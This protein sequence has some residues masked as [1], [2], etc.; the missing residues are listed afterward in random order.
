VRPLYVLRRGEVVHHIFLCEYVSGRAH[1]PKDAP[2]SSQMRGDNRFVPGWLPL[3][4]L[5]QAPFLIWQPVKR[6]L[7][8]D[9]ANGYRDSVIEIVADPLA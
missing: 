3:S 8:R 6:Q 4:E 2:E 7:L 1:L 9:L 5:R